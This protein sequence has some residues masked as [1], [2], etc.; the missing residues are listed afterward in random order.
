MAQGMWSHFDGPLISINGA[1]YFDSQSNADKVKQC[2]DTKS[3]WSPASE[4][5]RVAGG[6]GTAGKCSRLLRSKVKVNP[7]GNGRNTSQALLHSRFKIILHLERLQLS[8][9]GTLHGL[10]AAQQVGLRVV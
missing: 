9:A 3:L 10:L 6:S 1:W 7:T 2:L 4:M 5:A 8:A